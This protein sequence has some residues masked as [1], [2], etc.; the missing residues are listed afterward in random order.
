HF[1]GRI[2]TSA[3]S[4]D[5]TSPAVLDY[6]GLTK[7]AVESW[8]VKIFG[9]IGAA[10]GQADVFLAWGALDNTPEYGMW[11]QASQKFDLR[12]LELP[13]DLRAKLAK[14]EDLFERMLPVNILRGVEREFAVPART[15]T[16]VYE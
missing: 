8:G 3:A 15:G 1:P 7:E 12:Y 6:Y 11:Y 9:S 13:A 10:D 5:W 4:L 2:V 16:T 14:D